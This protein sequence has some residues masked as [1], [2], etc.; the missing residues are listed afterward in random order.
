MKEEEREVGEVKELLRFFRA[1][2]I[3]ETKKIVI[4]DPLDRRT[5]HGPQNHKYAIFLFLLSKSPLHSSKNS[6]LVTSRSRQDVLVLLI[7]TR[8]IDTDQ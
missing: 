3:S 2:Q 8:T 5:S 1:V 7:C 4:G 6:L